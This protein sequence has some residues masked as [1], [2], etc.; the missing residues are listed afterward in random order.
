PA[1]R[2]HGSVGLSVGPEVGIRDEAD[3]PLGPGETGQIVLRGR[4]VVAGYEADPEA[5]A[6]AFVDGWFRTGDL[7]H[8][9]ADGYLYV[10]GR[11]G[12]TI[13]R[14]GEKV[15]PQE[16]DAVLARHPDVAEATTF[17]VAHARLGEEVA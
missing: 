16:V 12:E 9:D 13:N 7:G 3:A 1:P 6:R 10:T 2:K 11:L 4:N 5:N 17:P 15:M 8:L 14:G